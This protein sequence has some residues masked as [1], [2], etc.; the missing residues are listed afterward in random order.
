MKQPFTMRII[1]SG[2]NTRLEV[3]N[4][5]LEVLNLLGFDTRKSKDSGQEVSLTLDTEAKTMMLQ[6]PEKEEL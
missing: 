5:L 2:S 6:W 1:G 3:K 4:G